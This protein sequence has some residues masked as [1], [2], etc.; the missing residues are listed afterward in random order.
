MASLKPERTPIAQP[1]KKELNNTLAEAVQSDNQ[2]FE[3]DPFLIKSIGDLQTRLREGGKITA[4]E[5]E[6]LPNSLQAL[7]LLNLSEPF[8]IRIPPE[9][10]KIVRIS[11]AR[12]ELERAKA[13]LAKLGY[14]VNT[15]HNTVTN[16][17][18][19]TVV[20][21][22]LVPDKINALLIYQ[23]LVEANIDAKVATSFVTSQTLMMRIG[24]TLIA[25]NANLYKETAR[26]TPMT[27]NPPLGQLSMETGDNPPY[28]FEGVPTQRANPDNAKQFGPDLYTSLRTIDSLKQ[29]EERDAEKESLTLGNASYLIINPHLLLKNSQHGLPY[30]LHILNNIAAISRSEDFIIKKDSLDNIVIIA[31]QER[32]S[33]FLEQFGL[34]LYQKSSGKAHLRFEAGNLRQNAEGEIEIADYPQIAEL[35]SWSHRGEKHSDYII[36][37]ET[38]ANLQGTRETTTS[39]LEVEEI[40]GTNY[41][42]I[43]NV[44]REAS[45]RVGGGPDRIIGQ[46]DILEKLRET[47]GAT[48]KTKLTLLKGQAGIGKSRILDE[49]R[50]EQP[51]SIALSID[52]A[53]EKLSGMALINIIEQLATFASQKKS[54]GIMYGDRYKQYLSP[55]YEIYRTQAAERLNLAQTDPKKLQTIILNA[56]CAFEKMFGSFTIILDDLHHIDS[57]SDTHI[58]KL[59]ERVFNETQ[60]R[61]IAT[62]RPEDRFKSTQQTAL[63]ATLTSQYGKNGVHTVWLEDEHTHRP[64]LNLREP[65]TARDYVFYSLPEEMRINKATGEEKQLTNNWHMMLAEKV[66]TPWQFTSLINILLRDPS[67]YLA[68]GENEISL[69]NEALSQLSE[70]TNQDDLVKHERSRI[71]KLAP[72]HRTTLQLIAMIG[73]QIEPSKLIQLATKA[74]GK[75]DPEAA[76]IIQFLIAQNYLCVI[77]NERKEPIAYELQNITIAETARESIG[78]KAKKEIVMRHYRSIVNDSSIPDE[79]KF[80]WLQDATEASS[81]KDHRQLWTE[82]CSKASAIMQKDRE[83]RQYSQGF[84]HASK[85]LCNLDPNSKTDVTKIINELCIDTLENT[86]KTILE[87][88]NTEKII[89]VIK[90]ALFTLIETGANL[91]QFGKVHEAI[92]KFE[93]ICTNTN[94]PENSQLAAAYLVG[95][96]MASI[97]ESHIRNMARRTKMNAYYGK[98][99]KNRTNYKGEDLLAIDMQYEARACDQGSMNNVVTKLEAWLD[100]YS[101]DG[102]A[103]QAVKIANPDA[104][105][106]IKLLYQRYQFEHISRKPKTRQNIDDDSAMEP[107]HFNH[108]ETAIL[109]TNLRQELDTIRQEREANPLLLDPIEE[110]AFLEL[111]AQT[112]SYCGEYERAEQAF[113]EAWRIG[114]QLSIP[115]QSARA[116]KLKGDIQIMKAVARITHPTAN[117][118]GKAEPLKHVAI[119]RPAI[120][121][122]INTYTEEGLHVMKKVDENDVYQAILRIQRIRAVSLLVQTYSREIS[123]TQNSARQQRET[124]RIK[125][126]TMP[127]LKLALQDFQ[128]LNMPPW[129][130]NFEAEDG[131]FSYYTV[132]SMGH[133][134]DFM[135]TTEIEEGDQIPRLN[136][137]QSLKDLPALSENAIKQGISKIARERLTDHVG[138]VDR[139]IEGFAKLIKTGKAQRNQ[140]ETSYDHLLESAQTEAMIKVNLDRKA[141]ITRQLPNFEAIEEALNTIERGRYT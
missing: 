36:T 98:I 6:K 109:T 120:L 26:T 33:G 97:E 111:L 122:A 85:V 60:C 2:R 1:T 96:K 130:E 87:L 4:E 57:H 84:A 55:L 95:F 61:I 136:D 137:P 75:P 77:L 78:K 34:A 89:G 22:E 62:M 56:I 39:R 138:E 12:K 128:E 9:D 29:Q 82:Y 40:P 13:L 103:A 47:T 90:E 73:S 107:S 7:A 50:Q 19:E 124:T 81:I 21:Q 129:A 100:K 66:Q 118:P 14:S 80:N 5:V 54:I 69:T 23:S 25:S 38:Y 131:E 76:R 93:A 8:S 83:G 141:A 123:Q 88:E 16:G 92:A 132:S 52:P 46:R 113:S 140:L 59:I 30:V 127:Y 27:I 71:R 102:P 115:R 105:A 45:L 74:T 28:R 24:N 17:N 104:F 110:L 44:V 58:M 135:E 101:L 106:K 20:I 48:S 15:D 41:L 72:E 121:Q 119:N 64:K 3:Q 35:L 67:K 134:L 10:Y 133:I 99:T 11:C 86:G 53:C 116:A 117:T 125:K 65:Q 126:E 94:D 114:N 31:L 32:A 18:D 68:V 63:E 49:L 37:K 139:K 43:K 108:E 42:R 112:Y 79:I 91:G 70:I 51:N